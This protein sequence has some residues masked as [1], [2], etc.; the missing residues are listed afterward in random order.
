MHRDLPGEDQPA[1][2]PLAE[3]PQRLAP[4]AESGG[5]SSA[6]KVFAPDC[7]EARRSGR[8]SPGSGASGRGS[9]ASSRAGRLDPAYAWTKTR[10]LPPI[11]QQ[12]F[13]EWWRTRA[14]ER[15][16]QHPGPH[17]RGA[18]SR[19][20]Q[21]RAS[22]D[23]AR[24]EPRCRRRRS[25]P[26]AAGGRPVVRRRS[27]PCSG[28]TPPTSAPT[29]A[30]SRTAGT[31]RLE[32]KTLC[33]REGWTA[34]GLPSRRVDRGRLPGARPAGAA[35]RR[36][37]STSASW[38]RCDVGISECD[39]LVA[40]TGTVVVTSRSAGGRALSVLPP[41]HVVLARR[42]QLVR[43]SAGSLRAAQGEVRRQTTRA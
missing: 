20:A 23:T 12:T 26:G 15:T 32:L 43:R 35:D 5:R 24:E 13:R 9:T 27:W 40:Q 37:A 10:D 33:A 11:A 7:H 8:W 22:T 42:A 16:R 31:L 21:A 30:C 34:R 19:R 29:S 36:R 4:E 38:R 41:H 14:H 2:S 39:A 17:P 25:A 3:P 6:F 28:R 1:P 18:R